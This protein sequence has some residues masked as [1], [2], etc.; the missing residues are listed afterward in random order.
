M[1]CGVCAWQRLASGALSPARWFLLINLLILVAGSLSAGW[2][3]SSQI[4]ERVIQRTI[5]INALYI[6]SFVAP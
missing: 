4:K 3:L 2:W 1:A 5:R 6:E